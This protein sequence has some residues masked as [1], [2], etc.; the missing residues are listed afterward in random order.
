M[1]LATL[2]LV[3][4]IVLFL[5]DAFGVSFQRASLQSLG[6]ASFALSFLLGGIALA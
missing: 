3:V 6:L 2:F 1:T 4:A 5:L